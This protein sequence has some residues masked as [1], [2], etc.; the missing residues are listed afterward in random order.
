MVVTAAVAVDIQAFWCL[1]RYEYLS[2]S[3]YVTSH[4]GDVASKTAL[5][6]LDS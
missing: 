6:Q 1:T 2:I 4:D 3:E 5:A